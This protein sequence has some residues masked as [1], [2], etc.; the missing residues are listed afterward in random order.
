L[1]NLSDDLLQSPLPNN[2]TAIDRYACTP[3]IIHQLQAVRCSC[4]IICVYIC[5][6]MHLAH[7][8][9]CTHIQSHEKCCYCM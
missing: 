6:C 3:I 8:C 5:N 7:A 2:A 1:C 9:H 4:H